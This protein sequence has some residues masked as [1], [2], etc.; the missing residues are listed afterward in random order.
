MEK[1]GLERRKRPSAELHTA[2]NLVN[3]LAGNAIALHQKAERSSLVIARNLAKSLAAEEAGETLTAM[4][5][6]GECVPIE[7]VKPLIS[8]PRV[9]WDQDF[10]KVPSLST[11]PEKPYIPFSMYHIPPKILEVK[12]ALAEEN[13]NKSWNHTYYVDSKGEG[14]KVHVCKS[15]EDCE[16]V[17]P[18]FLDEEV[19]G[20]DLEWVFPER[21]KT[22]IRQNVAVI[23]VASESTIAIIHVAQIGCDSNGKPLKLKESVDE[24]ISPTL[25]KL[26]ESDRVLK[27][28]VNVLGDH[29]RLHKFLGVKPQGVFELSDLHNLVV[30]LENNMPKIPKRLFAL[31]K[32]TRAHLGLPLDKGPVRVSDW[33]K[34]MSN[35]QAKYAAADTY[36]GLRIFDVLET[37]RMALNPRPRRPECRAIEDT[38]EDCAPTTTTTS[39]TVTS[40]T[41]TKTT[42]LTSSVITAIPTS[43]EGCDT[44]S[45]TATPT[46]TEGR[47]TES[48]TAT[49]TSTEGCDTESLSATPTSTEGCDP[50][51]TTATPTSTE[52]CDTESLSETSKTTTITEVFSAEIEVAS[53]WIKTYTSSCGT[54]PPL[55]KPQMRAYALWHHAE[56]ELADIAKIW[57]DPPLSEETVAIYLLEAIKTEKLPYD[58]L[59]V[60]AAAKHVPYYLK[61][62]FKH[63]WE[64][65]VEV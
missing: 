33:S 3:A 56:L 23:Q 7:V 24:L 51:T 54:S 44:E 21:N 1:L 52:G 35:V 25:R 31:A 65:E 63:I 59:R 49:P 47:E 61:D 6:P 58:A 53:Q 64:Q 18:Q 5:S 8:S 10:A 9:N 41:T 28:G 43:A 55:S 26:I 2:L 27:V 50:E 4:E 38:S 42:V 39:T 45:T 48:P 57:R 32:Q 37:R 29:R 46:S 11:E 62:R 20:F 17:L 36:A 14:V 34:P 12:M 13:E 15:L 30:S 40:T 22:S 60:R 16:K 19:V